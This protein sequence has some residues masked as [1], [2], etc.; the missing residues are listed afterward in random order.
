M[1]GVQT[2]ALPISFIGRISIFK[3]NSG[4][5]T[6]DTEVL[7]ATRNEKEKIGQIFYLRGNKQIPTDEIIA[8]DIGATVKLDFTETGDTLCTK[9]NPIIFSEI[10]FVKPCF[11][12][13]V[14]PA[15]KN[16]DEKLSM[17]IQKMAE[18]D[19][20]FK[21]VR[22]HET[23]QLL[24]GGQGEKQLYIKIGRAHV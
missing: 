19:P 6:K 18:E 14:L 11:Y 20:T 5:L 21:V 16:D 15:N 24:I 9:E 2:C 1:T 13:G 7:N 22:N 8:G 17:S 12:A 3:V 10:K 4:V 23:K